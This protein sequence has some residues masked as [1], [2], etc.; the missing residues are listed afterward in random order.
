MLFHFP[1]RHSGLGVQLE[2]HFHVMCKLSNFMHYKNILLSSKPRDFGLGI[3]NPVCVICFLTVRRLVHWL[4]GHCSHFGVSDFLILNWQSAPT[5]C[6]WVKLRKVGNDDDDTPTNFLSPNYSL[7]RDKT[8][9]MKS[10]Y[11]WSS[12]QWQNHSFLVWRSL[13]GNYR[14]LSQTPALH[15]PWPAAR[16]SAINDNYP[17]GVTT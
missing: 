8:R 5:P 14:V 16:M 9:K 1:F 12:L 15:L 6:E 13:D 10:H 3:S 7:K 11:V 2:F 17:P 4:S